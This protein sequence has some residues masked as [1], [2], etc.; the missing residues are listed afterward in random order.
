MN[1]YKGIIFD[2]DGTLLDTLSDL[3]NSVN[4]VLAVYGYPT[5]TKEAYRLKIGRGFR[6]LIE[7]SMPE[8]T[9]TAIIE[10]GL[11]RFLEAYDRNYCKETKPYEGIVLV[12]R[13]LRRNGI[14]LAVNSNKRD[15]YT[16]QLIKLLLP[17][18]E[19][20]AI[21]GEREGVAKKPDPQAAWEIAKQMALDTKDILYVG[22]SKTDMVTATNAG[23]NSIGVLWGFRDEKELDEHKATYIVKRP[24]GI[25][26][27]A[28]FGS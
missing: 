22:D 25:Y 3:A 28:V 16:R 7:Q 17:D 6:N 9:D 1:K 21:Y 4:E 26:N 27:I 19:F 23:M 18:I 24:Q 10:A 15:D 8:N 12:L 5:H 13:A 14:L 11:Q 2:L 20:V